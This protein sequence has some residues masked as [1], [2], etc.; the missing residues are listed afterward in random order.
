LIGASRIDPSDPPGLLR[1]ALGIIEHSGSA[2]SSLAANV[3]VLEKTLVRA[4]NVDR[5]SPAVALERGVSILEKFGKDT[6]PEELKARIDTALAAEKTIATVREESDR[7][8]RERDNLMRSGKGSTFPS[9][10]LTDRGDT[11]YIFDVSIRDTGVVVKDTSPAYRRSDQ[12]WKLLEDLH[13]DES[14]PHQ[15]HLWFGCSNVLDSIRSSGVRA[16]LRRM[17]VQ[18][19]ARV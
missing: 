17:R 16:V 12:S 14:N 6:N 1:R 2:Q 19:W 3:S 15:R 7:Y 4:S 5:E 10:W 18:G 9:C 11:E 13:K 8:R